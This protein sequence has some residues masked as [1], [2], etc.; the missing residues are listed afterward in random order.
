M[1]ESA[2]D[3]GV[4]TNRK[5][6]SRTKSIIPRIPTNVPSIQRGQARIQDTVPEITMGIAV[7]APAANNI[8]TT[9]ESVVASGSPIASGVTKN[10]QNSMRA[11][12]TTAT[13]ISARAKIMFR[14]AAMIFP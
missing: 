12:S 7:I 8:T 1:T 13:A 6:S 9:G 4:A 3:E 14:I 2:V 5:P 11:S 10:P